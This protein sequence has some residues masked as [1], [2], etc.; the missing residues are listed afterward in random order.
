MYS[1]HTRSVEGTAVGILLMCTAHVQ[2]HGTPVRMAFC[3]LLLMCNECTRHVHGTTVRISVMRTS[4]VQGK[5][6][7]QLSGFQ[8]CVHLMH[9]QK[10]IHGTAVRVAVMC[11][12]Y[13]KAKYTA[14][15]S[16]LHGVYNTC[17]K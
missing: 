17:T 3:C 2:V 15:L 14:Q 9:T 12:A 11:T 8:L 6:M 4:W 10:Q 13:A 5:Y 16:G 7:A 1:L